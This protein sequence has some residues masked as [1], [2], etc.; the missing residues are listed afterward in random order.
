MEEV[1]KNRIILI[2]SVLMIIFFIGAMG[3]CSNARKIKAECDKE[4]FNRLDVEEKMN[5]LIHEKADIEEKL[6]GVIRKLAEETTACQ[7]AKKMLLQE[8]LISKNLNEELQKM[9]ELKEALEEDL[10]EALV[11]NKPVKPKK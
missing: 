6:N 2:L 10:K 1:V 9:T 3:S 4:I 7:L 8:Q 5:N 11:A